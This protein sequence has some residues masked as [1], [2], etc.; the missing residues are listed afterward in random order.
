MSDEKLMQIAFLFNKRKKWQLENVPTPIQQ[1][2]TKTKHSPL[3]NNK[4]K[5]K[6]VANQVKIRSE[7][8]SNILTL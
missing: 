8:Y 4:K 6:Q 5:K 1:V 7:Y 2:G 3:N